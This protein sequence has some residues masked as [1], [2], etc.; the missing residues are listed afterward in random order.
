MIEQEEKIKN[1]GK[2]AIEEGEYKLRNA[3]D[4]VER[5]LKQGHEHATKFAS[6]VNKQAHDNPWP[7]VVGVGVGCLLLGM[8]LSKS[9]D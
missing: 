9:R 8:L 4:E 1:Y 5:R 3:I 7:I 6:D 2:H